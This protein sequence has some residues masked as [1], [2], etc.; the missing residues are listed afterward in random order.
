M[1]SGHK[2]QANGVCRPT[3]WL[4]REERGGGRATVHCHCHGHGGSGRADAVARLV[5]G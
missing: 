5:A 3:V 2:S 4:E 1:L